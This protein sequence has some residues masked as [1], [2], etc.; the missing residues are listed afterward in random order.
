MSAFWRWLAQPFARAAASEKSGRFGWSLLLVDAILYSLV[1][2]VADGYWLNRHLDGA[3]IAIL[4]VGIVIFH[5]LCLGYSH[6]RPG[7]THWYFVKVA[8]AS[9]CA[10]AVFPLIFDYLQISLGRIGFSVV[11]A[12]G[13]LPQILLHLAHRHWRQ[14]EVSSPLEPLRWVLLAGS[15]MWLGFP[16]LSNSK[17]GTGDAYWYGS[18]V[19]DFVTQWRA[20]VFPVFVGQSDFAFNG[21]VSPV[22]LAPYLQHAAGILDLL[23]LRTLSFFGLVNLT[24]FISLLTAAF[25]T[26]ATLVAIEKRG[27][28]TGCLM[29]LLFVSS[30]AVLSL[31]YTGDLFL[32]VCALPYLPLVMYGIWHTFQHRNLRSVC[33]LAAAL[34]AIWWCH[35]PIAFWAT[36]IAALS[37]V[38][39]IATESPSRRVWWHWFAG[40]AL[41]AALT[42]GV[43]VSVLTLHLPALSA[44][45]ILI[46]RSLE[47]AFPGALLPVSEGANLLSDYQL[48]WSLWL[49]LLL[50]GS[51]TLFRPAVFRLSLVIGSGLLLLLLLPIPHVTKPL[52]FLLPQSVCDLTFVWPMQRFYVLLGIMA[53]FLGYAGAGAILPQ[54]RGAQLAL[55]GGLLVAL[56]WSASEAGRFLQGGLNSVASADESRVMHLPQ[57]RTLTRYAYNSFPSAPPYFSHGYINPLW[58]NRLLA[59]GSFREIGSN[60]QAL[61]DKAMIGHVEG[62]LTARRYGARSSFYELLPA[63]AIEPGRRYALELDFAHPELAGTLLITGPTVTR[64]YYLPDSGVGVGLNRASTAFGALPTGKRSVSLLSNSGE[65]EKLLI[66]FVPAG[67]LEQDISKFGQFILREYDPARLPVVVETWAPYRAKVISPAPA[68]LETPRIFIEGYRA[69]ANGREVP[70][71][72]SPDGLVML[73]VGAGESHVTLSYPGPL[74]LRLS[75]FL[76]LVAWIGLIVA[77]IFG[78]CRGRRPVLPV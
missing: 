70:V 38:L 47:T 68:W 71:A 23:T 65:L 31:I 46:V 25:T 1:F 37:Q 52:W 12:A 41:F 39:R 17:M 61:S 26:Y 7:A 50:G 34:A 5:L 66:Q 75:Y 77:G 64:E 3:T 32:S 27:R 20:G 24:L 19:A 43:F 73:L 57:N 69:S 40:A 16:F 56:V 72:R 6:P 4:A 67:A 45:P 36:L 22:R 2:N 74:S 28:W 15:G 30:P 10:I 78:R 48:G 8:V 44:N 42:V 18:M 54:R 13:V 53:V 76:S 60:Y 55:V 62:E 29:A 63:L 14:Q 49:L 58:E 35:P 21:A 9:T 33:F 11:L 59:P 51:T